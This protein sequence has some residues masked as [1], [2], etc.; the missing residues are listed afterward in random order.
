[1][2]TSEASEPSQSDTSLAR[3]LF[4]R[5]SGQV[6]HVSHA[7]AVRK[8]VALRDIAEKRPLSSAALLH[9]DNAVVLLDRTTR[10][11]RD[12]A[13]AIVQTGELVVDEKTATLAAELRAQSANL[14][15]TLILTFV[16]ICTA[17]G[18]LES[19][20]AGA[21][22]RH[23]AVARLGWHE[24]TRDGHYD[25]TTARLAVAHRARALLSRTADIYTLRRDAELYCMHVRTCVLCENVTHNDE[26]D[27]LS[28]G[29]ITT[30]TI[31]NAVANGND[32]EPDEF[33]RAALSA[34][35]SELGQT[36]LRD[37]VISFTIPAEV[38]GVRSTLLIPRATAS[39]VVESYPEAAQVAHETAMAGT[40]WTAENIKDELRI[41][42]AVLAGLACLLAGHEDVR[43]ARSNP[44]GGVVYLPFLINSPPAGSTTHIF[45]NASTNAWTAYRLS[46]GCVTTTCS[47][48]G[49]AGLYVC[50]SCLL[51]ERV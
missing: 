47:A 10:Q 27:F 33:V 36:I 45:F 35:E 44:F 46:R 49:L 2:H 20:G 1:M 11:L 8:L 38:L 17:G 13:V 25:P 7:K 37:L 12:E 41:A 32:A 16:L 34:G 40:V 14:E 22:A 29:A 51:S 28:L 50:T 6:S 48:H 9:L 21:L 24:L 15:E 3:S 39:L 42:C 43:N 30:S 31:A 19:D 5:L 23:E 26:T 18:W 4:A